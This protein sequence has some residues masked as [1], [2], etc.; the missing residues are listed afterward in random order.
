VTWLRA[1]AS[2]W[3]GLSGL[4]G[5]SANLDAGTDT[6]RGALPVDERSAIVMINDGGRDNWQG[7]YAVVLAARREVR[8]VGMVVNS[9]SIYPSLE[10]NIADYRALIAAARGSGMTHLPDP[11]A[12]VAPGLMRPDSG[13]IEDTLPNRSEGARLILDAAARYG[14]AVHPLVIAT[15]NALTDAADAFLMD[16]SLPE[17]A[18][19]VSSL[20]TSNGDGAR[21]GSPNGDNDLWATIIV[22]ARMRFVQVNGYYDQLLDV[23]DA[24]VA[25][26]PQNPFGT[27][28]AEKRAEILALTSACDQ[29]SILSSALPWFASGV[30]RM[31]A[32]PGDGIPVLTPDPTGQIWHVAQSDS[33]RARDEI[34]AALK[35]PA[36]F[37]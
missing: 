12:S 22:T 35:D 32:E 27:Y 20:G 21:S 9:S 29:V 34:W 26:L 6:P 31:R 14:T 15:G 24:R 36:T 25:E 37:R 28:M 5:C 30:A 19:V 17:R 33:D 4:W 13:V 18:V 23:P 7:E 10:Q 2:C 16:P 1:C 11:I 8:L 3:L